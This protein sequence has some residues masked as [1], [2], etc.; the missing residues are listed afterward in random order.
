MTTVSILS[1][2]HLGAKNADIEAFKKALKQADKVILLGDIIDSISK[3]DRRHDTKDTLM[4]VTDQITT[5]TNVLKPYKRKILMYY[6]GNH[7]NSFKSHQDID[8][9]NLICSDLNIKEMDS[10]IITIDG[11]DLFCTHG[12][13]NGATYGGN[14]TKLINYNRDFTAEYFITGHSHRL[15]NMRIAHNP[16]PFTIISAGCFIDSI[17]YGRQKAYPDSIMG[18][19]KLNCKTR[20]LTEVII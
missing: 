5:L 9:V 1:D 3:K 2:L 19:Y 18:Y 17:K 4:S 20:K 10:G 16:K 8:L 7:E 14:V 13:G 12:N 15:F 11:I 6:P